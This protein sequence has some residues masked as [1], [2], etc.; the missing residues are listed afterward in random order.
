MGSNFKDREYGMNTDEKMKSFNDGDLSRVHTKR[1]KDDTVVRERRL[2][3]LDEIQTMI[4]TH[5]G[6]NL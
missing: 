3:L 5:K 4:N 2:K 6:N 1:D